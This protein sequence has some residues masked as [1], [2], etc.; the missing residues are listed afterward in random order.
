MLEKM[1]KT[2]TPLTRRLYGRLVSIPGVSND[3]LE[4]HF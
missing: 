4:T 2:R 3:Y 1:K